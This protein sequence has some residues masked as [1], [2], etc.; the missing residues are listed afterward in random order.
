MRIPTLLGL[1]ILITII[2]FA[3][4]FYL[5]RQDNNSKIRDSLAPLSIRYTNVTDNSF[6][7]TWTSPQE[8]AGS[9]SWGTSSNL[10]NHQADD[11]DQK[12]PTDRITHSATLT[13]LQENTNYFFKIRSGAF[14]YPNQPLSVKTTAKLQ[15]T[16]QNPVIG[17]LLDSDLKPLTDT[18]VFLEI[19]GA[20]PLSAI[21]NAEGFFLIPL[22]D[23]KTTDLK[24]TLKL[25]EKTTGIT[26][27]QTGLSQSR[28]KVNLPAKSPLTPVLLGQDIDLTAQDS[29]HSAK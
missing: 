4:M 18:I 3:T 28:I 23:L 14:F 29:T 15:P 2:L 13:N 1:T 7:V 10:G 17:K 11:R 27:I 8:T 20:A 5:Y 9:L 25:P 22:A 6:T 16:T 21:P 24:S 19:S 26:L 12:N